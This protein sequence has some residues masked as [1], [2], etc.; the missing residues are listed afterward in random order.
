[1]DIIEL[2]DYCIAKPSVTESFPFDQN[3][4]VFK[5]IGK[6][7]ALTNVNHYQTVNLKC[8]PDWAEELRAENPLIQPG[9]HMNKKHWNTVHV[10]DFPDSR[11]MRKMIDNSYDLVVNKLTRAQKEVL[12]KGPPAGGP[13]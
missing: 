13:F 3:T 2:R 7:F 5:V 1:M 11:L 12:K 9:Y 4:L 8:D 6:M 10:V